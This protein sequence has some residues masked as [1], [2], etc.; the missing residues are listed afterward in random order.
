MQWTIKTLLSD[1]EYDWGVLQPQDLLAL[2]TM[3]DQDFITPLVAPAACFETCGQ[4][5][6]NVLSLC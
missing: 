5:E 2:D 4:A 3:T 6:R 1:S